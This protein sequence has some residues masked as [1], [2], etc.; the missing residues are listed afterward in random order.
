[1]QH[2]RISKKQIRK[3]G[4]NLAAGLLSGDERRKALGLVGHWRA[5]HIEPLHR[6]LGML[7][8]ICGQD[9][10]TILV[11]RL[12]R[13]DTIINKLNRPGYHF[14]LITLRDIAGCRLIVPNEDDVRREE[15][16]AASQYTRLE[17]DA[18]ASEVYL[19]ARAASLDDLRRAYPNYYSDI[20]EF[21]GWLKRCIE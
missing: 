2:D 14:N 11:S 9:E 6:T 18:V 5:A 7:E 3:A 20:S 21:V 16:A 1:M 13:I 17:S 10:S 8:S 4:D 19:L 12:K 15:E